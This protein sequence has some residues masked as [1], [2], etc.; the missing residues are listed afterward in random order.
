MIGV[1]L[2]NG[3]I[4]RHRWALVVVEG[5]VPPLAAAVA[6]VKSEVA[7]EGDVEGAICVPLL[8]SACLQKNN[9]NPINIM[10]TQR[11]LV[12]ISKE[13]N[14]FDGGDIERPGKSP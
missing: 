4:Y 1:L 13:Q 7:A 10:C 11:Q 12:Q 2:V 14:R 9:N 5:E 8:D 3:A 6:A